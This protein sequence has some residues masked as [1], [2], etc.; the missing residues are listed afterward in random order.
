MFKERGFS[1]CLFAHN[2]H[3][4]YV[5]CLLCEELCLSHMLRVDA[6]L[7]TDLEREGILQIPK[8]HGSHWRWI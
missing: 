4:A 1:K 6:L 5:S 8:C 3:L 7:L 2:G